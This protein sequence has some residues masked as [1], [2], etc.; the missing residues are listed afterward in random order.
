MFGLVGCGVLALVAATLLIGIVIG[1]SGTETAPE[2]ALEEQEQ[3]EETPDEPAPEPEPEPP[4]ATSD[5]TAT[6]AEAD[7]TCEIGQACDLGGSTVTVTRVQYT[8]GVQNL[9]ETME[10]YFVVVDFDYTYYEEEPATTDLPPFEL[11]DEDENMYSLDSTATIAYGV[12]AGRSLTYAT[13]QPEVP[14][15]GAAVFKVSPEA[16]EFTLLVKD[17]FLPDTRKTARVPLGEARF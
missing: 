17:L 11:S 7:L 13:V 15:P 2:S 1:M 4:S 16:Q 8:R 10:G 12:E 9:G 3:L 6:P 5:T 14:T